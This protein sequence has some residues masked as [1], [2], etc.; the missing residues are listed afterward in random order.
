MTTN[1]ANEMTAGSGAPA[2]EARG[3]TKS[4]GGHRAV[5][6]LSFSVHA[7]RVTGF[8]GPN[9][10]GKSTTMRLLLGLERPESGVALI[11]GRPYAEL[12]APLTRVGALLDAKAF[13]KGLS[14]HD[15]LLA[16]AWSQAL[17]SSRVDEVLDLVGLGSVARKRAGGFSLGMAQ[18][19]GIAAALLGD[20]GIVL[21]DEPV[22]GLDPEGVLWIRTLMKRLAAEGRAVLV[23]SHLMNEMAVTAD[24]LLVIG[25]GRLL[26]DSPTAEFIERHTDPAVYAATPDVAKPALL[27]EAFMRLTAG[28]VQYAAR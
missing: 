11:D 27:E 21:L 7:G 9:G 26:A 12:I 22:N 20:P 1:T 19:L 17:P 2:I 8:L 15:H 16:L 25:R 6:D 28:A 3:L 18:R 5:D 13:H 24:H 14:A 10:A 4:Y 23:S